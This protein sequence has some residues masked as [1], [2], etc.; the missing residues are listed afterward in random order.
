M[1]QDTDNAVKAAQTADLLCGDLQ[2]LVKS[3]NRLLS[4]IALEILADAAR[5]RSRILDVV[6]DLSDRES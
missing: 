3:Q 4:R 6:C 1:N 2:D 5:M